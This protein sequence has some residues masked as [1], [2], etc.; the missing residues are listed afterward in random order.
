MSSSIRGH[1]GQFKIFKDGAPANIVNLT[2]VDINQESSFS[3]SF[4][5]GNS[6]GE[7]DQT[8]EGWSGSVEA[9]VKDA[10]V[11]EFIDALIEDN[12]N[13]IGVSDYIFVVTENYADGRSKSHVYFD[14]QFKMSRSQSGL[15]EKITKRLEFQAAG[16]KAL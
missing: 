12:L 14:C 16:R 1:S 9:E 4:Y 3:R 2:K 6:V 8:C 13:G 15:N 5:V 7:G 11:D 10:A